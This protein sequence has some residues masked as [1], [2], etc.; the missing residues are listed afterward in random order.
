[1]PRALVQADLFG[2][3]VGVDEVLSFEGESGEAAALETGGVHQPVGQHAQILVVRGRRGQTPHGLPRGAAGE[4]Q[5]QP[6]C[7]GCLVPLPQDLSELD[8][9]GEQSGADIGAVQGVPREGAAG[10]GGGGEGPGDYRS[11]IDAAGA[12]GGLVSG[13]AAEQALHGGGRL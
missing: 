4:P 11:G 6:E 13:P 12:F 9:E 5:R 2:D 7:P 8:D 10:R 3:L 1:M